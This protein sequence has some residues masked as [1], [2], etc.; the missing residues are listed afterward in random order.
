MSRASMTR[1]HFIAIA[2]DI[3]MALRQADTYLERLSLRYLQ[4]L[5]SVTMARFNPNFDRQRWVDHIEDIADQRKEP[6]SWQ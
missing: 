2:D 5:L 1:Q 3:G 4:G 6:T